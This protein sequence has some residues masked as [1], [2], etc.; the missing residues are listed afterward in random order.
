MSWRRQFYG[1]KDDMVKLTPIE[2]GILLALMAEGKELQENADIKTRLKIG[3]TASH[4]KKLNEAGFIITKSGPFSHSLTEAGWVFLQD[5]FPDD[6]P[7]SAIQI[8]PMNTLFAGVKRVLAMRQ[9]RLKDFFT[10]EP[11]QPDETPS[12][13]E[14]KD[15]L[16]DAA[17]S[18][19]EA[20]LAI[21]LQDIPAF[22]LRAKRLSA[23]SSDQVLPEFEQVYLAA[24]VIFQNVKLVARQRGLS[25]LYQRGDEVEFDPALFE[26]FDEP[27]QGESVT[28]RKQPI[29]KDVSGSRL[30]V[31][32][33][34]AEICD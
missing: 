12:Q 30:V 24:E 22:E 26:C 20:S 21:A 29:V 34:I 3:M 23:S 6:V 2:R 33:G 19:S 14:P 28:V 15:L 16:S 10:G 17:W 25:P 18:D 13:R 9:T 8:A 27:D 11:S 1:W 7:S 4:R 5:S 31:A 32:R